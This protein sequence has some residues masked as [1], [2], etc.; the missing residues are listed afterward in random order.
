MAE[1]KSVFTEVYIATNG[2]PCFSCAMPYYDAQGIA[3]VLGVDVNLSSVQELV[4]KNA[5]NEDET[6]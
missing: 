5:T 2:M 1:K 4:E 6:N 3:G